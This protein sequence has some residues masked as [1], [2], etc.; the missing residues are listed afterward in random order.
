MLRGAKLGLPLHDAKTQL[1]WQRL[2]KPGDGRIGLK[3]GTLR[4]IGLGVDN[5]D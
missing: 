3:I 5:R 2:H 4:W 1:V